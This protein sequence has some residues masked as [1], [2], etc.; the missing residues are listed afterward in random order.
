[1]WTLA[2][3]SVVYM[4]QRVSYTIGADHYVYRV[5]G[6][7]SPRQFV[8]VRA[9]AFDVDGVEAD[10]R[11]VKLRKSKRHPEGVWSDSKLNRGEPVGFWHLYTT[12]ERDQWDPHK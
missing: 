11:I 6:V 3:G 9:C 12:R 8:A 4:G 10:A 2:D 1:M 7:R 5:I